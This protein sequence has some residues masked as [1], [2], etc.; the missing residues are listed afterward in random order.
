MGRLLSGEMQ[1]HVLSTLS[2][3]GDVRVF[4]DG[5]IGKLLYDKIHAR[6]GKPVEIEEIEFIPYQKGEKGFSFTLV[7][8]ELSVLRHNGSAPRYTPQISALEQREL[9]VFME[10]LRNRVQSFLGAR[11]A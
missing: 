9:S 6:S 5:S 7:E 11:A 4:V 3:N 1:E 8:N 2:N 10:T